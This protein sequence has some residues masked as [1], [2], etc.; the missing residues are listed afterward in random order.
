MQSLVFIAVH[1][2]KEIRLALLPWHNIETVLL[3]MD[4]TLLDLHFDN[5]FWL[6]HLPKKL[7]EKEGKTIEESRQEMRDSYARV[8]G[9]IEWYCLDYWTEKL[10][11][12]IVE[13]KHEIAHL[14]DLRPDTIPFLDA[15]KAC[16]K[17]VV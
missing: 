15:L 4:G 10:G 9:Q 12:D 17:K 14:I 6:E 2:H 1:Y 13:A 5:Q 16:N 3:D 11:L 8:Q 7:A